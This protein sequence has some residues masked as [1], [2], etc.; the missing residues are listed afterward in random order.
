MTID[1]DFQPFIKLH[2][3]SNWKTR[4]GT[5]LVMGGGKAETIRSEP[6][7]SGYARLFDQFLSKPS[8]KLMVI[9]YGFGDDHIN[10]SL[11]RA[12]QGHG[13]SMF[14][15]DPRGADLAKDI[16]QTR[17]RGQIAC[18][19]PI[20]DLFERALVGA[21]RRSLCDTIWR[22]RIENDKVESFFR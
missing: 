17:A 11:I 1:P 20:E 4:T 15:I 14:V 10:Q 5:L 21:S 3:S 13:L 8:T 12:A 22:D 19:T 16:N 9:G 2:G 7:L 6:L 18:P